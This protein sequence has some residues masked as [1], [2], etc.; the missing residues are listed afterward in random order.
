MYFVGQVGGWNKRGVL[1]EF[2]GRN[3]Y[4]KDFIKWGG[5]WDLSNGEDFR[6]E[7][8]MSKVISVVFFWKIFF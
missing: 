1:Q 2:K 6:W 4:V 7:Y 8:G 3:E 5:G